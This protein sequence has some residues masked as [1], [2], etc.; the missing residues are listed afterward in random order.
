MS[1]CT[2]PSGVVTGNAAGQVEHG[3]D[4]AD[5]RPGRDDQLLA[6][7]VAR[8]GLHGGHRAA[9]HPQP[10][11]RDPGLDGHAFGLRLGGQPA[12][13]GQV[14][15][16]PAPL[17]VQQHRG[18]GRLPIREQAGQVGLA[19]AGA[20]DQ[21]GLVPDGLLLGVDLPDVGPHA[22]RRDLQVAH[23]MVG[24][25][26]RV[27]VPDAHRVRHQLA[28]GRLE[29]VVPDHPAGHPGRACPDAGLVDDQDVLTA[30]AAGGAQPAG[31]VPGRGQAVDARANDDEPGLLL[32]HAAH[33]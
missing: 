9:V 1:G 18:P 7:D 8:L 10:G 28:H 25:C 22:L 20:V 33:P 15:G 19:R 31:Q 14:V 32:S 30:A 23:R 26:L 17:L 4:V 24:E 5:P 21:L 11:H 3:P 29:V 6:G 16:V 2:V 12:Q 27:G 13:R